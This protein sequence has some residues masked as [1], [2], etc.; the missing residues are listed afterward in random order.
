MS[1]AVAS[2]RYDLGVLYSPLPAIVLTT[3]ALWREETYF[4]CHR[5]DE[6][7][8][9]QSVGCRHVLQSPL[10]LPSSPHGIRALLEEQAR[11][12]STPLNTAVEV[13]S[14]QLAMELVRQGA[15]NMVLTERAL[16]D[17]AARQLVAVPIRRPTLVRAA[18]LAASEAALQR[19][20]VQAMWEFITPEL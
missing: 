17:L 20:A 2:G 6:R 14:L 18:H 19:P 3:K 12:H 13:D 7:A 10:I 1:E 15:G 9:A 4:I 8:Q 11:E 5:S 16:P